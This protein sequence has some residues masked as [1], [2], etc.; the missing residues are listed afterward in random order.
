MQHVLMRTWYYLDP[1]RPEVSYEGVKYLQL[2]RSLNNRN[3]PANLHLLVKRRW[4]WE[5]K[6]LKSQTKRTSD[7]QGTASCIQRV[8]PPLIQSGFTCRGVNFRE[9]RSRWRHGWDNCTIATV[10]ALGLSTKSEPSQMM[11]CNSMPCSQLSV[12]CRVSRWPSNG[13]RLKAHVLF[14][15]Q[16]ISIQFQNKLYFLGWFPSLPAHQIQENPLNKSHEATPQK[17][18]KT[19]TRMV[20]Y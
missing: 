12:S 19:S 15:P 3:W 8:Q 18:N 16:T 10:E 14:L 20:P 1:S 5:K 9:A 11:F 6:G 4:L 13:I 2:L 7:P 17:S